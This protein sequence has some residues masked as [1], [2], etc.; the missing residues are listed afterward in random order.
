MMGRVT[1]AE[2][3]AHLDNDIRVTRQPLQQELRHLEGD[4]H[5]QLSR[6]LLHHLHMELL[7]DATVLAGQALN[8]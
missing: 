4:V 1:R 2:A 3:A 8:L 6:L 7:R 5:Q